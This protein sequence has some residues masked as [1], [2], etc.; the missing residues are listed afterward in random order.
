[1][2]N[3]GA[4]TDWKDNDGQAAVHIAARRCELQVLKYFHHN[5][6][7]DFNV[8]DN[9][10]KKP[11]DLIPRRGHDNAEACRR[12]ILS[13]TGQTSTALISSA[14]DQRCAVGILAPI[15]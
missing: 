8:Q 12:F 15:D 11:I 6:G 7:L 1:L 5:L 14:R 2:C 4:P 9:M 13:T 3:I 10:G